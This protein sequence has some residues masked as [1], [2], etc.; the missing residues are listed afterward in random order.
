HQRTQ[1]GARADYLVRTASRPVASSSPC[2][3]RH[4]ARANRRAADGDPRLWAGERCRRARCEGQGRGPDG[5]AR[6]LKFCYPDE[7]AR[8]RIEPVLSRSW[9]RARNATVSALWLMLAGQACS[10]AFVPGD[11]GGWSLAVRET[12]DEA[13]A[14]SLKACQDKQQPGCRVGASLG[15][16]QFGCMAIAKKPDVGLPSSATG[17]GLSAVRNA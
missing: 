17:G 14:Q 15:P 5:R 2:G 4:E 9:H 7:A 6:R 11:N 1:N 16:F 8:R 12:F 3:E 10:V 13:K